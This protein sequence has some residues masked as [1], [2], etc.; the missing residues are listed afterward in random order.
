M[1]KLFKESKIDRQD[2]T[3]L[4]RNVYALQ[5]ISRD[6]Q[7]TAAEFEDTVEKLKRIKNV[8]HASPVNAIK[9]RS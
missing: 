6:L 2:Y 4:R 7:I 1:W 8:E 9:R 3:E 5:E